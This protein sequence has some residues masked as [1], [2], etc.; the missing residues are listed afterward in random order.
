MYLVVAT[1]MQFFKL[2]FLSV[3]CTLFE[4]GFGVLKSI[5]DPVSPKTFGFWA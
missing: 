1:G 3:L 5:L 4:K 2:S